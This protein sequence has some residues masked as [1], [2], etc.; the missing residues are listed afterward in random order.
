MG[1]EFRYPPCWPAQRRK[2]GGGREELSVSTHPYPRVY[3]YNNRCSA[4]QKHKHAELAEAQ[5]SIY[6]LL[7]P[8]YSL[9]TPSET[10]SWMGSGDKG[11]A[12]RQCTR[13]CHLQ[14]LR[15]HVHISQAH[16]RTLRPSDI[17]KQIHQPGA[18]Q[19]GPQ[20]QRSCG[21]DL[22]IRG[23]NWEVWQGHV[24]GPWC[25]FILPEPCLFRQDRKWTSMTQW[26]VCTASGG[27][28]VI[29]QPCAGPARLEQVS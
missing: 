18:G 24:T 5:G 9:D 3:N 27:W 29:R 15:G 19:T 4:T 7:E 20:G 17:S 21:S 11:H 13:D 25:Y 16:V 8:T 23:F 22:E 12:V 10:N 1:F 28:G 2:S 14:F 6:N 26:K